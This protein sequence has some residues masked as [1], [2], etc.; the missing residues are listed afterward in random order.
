MVHAQLVPL[1]E[2]DRDFEMGILS[3]QL[4]SA[5]QTDTLFKD[6]PNNFK[7]ITVHQQLA[8]S[9]PP[10]TTLLAFTD[11][12][13]HSFK[14]DNRLFWAFQFHPEVDKQVLID[15]LTLYKKKYTNDDGHLAAILANAQETPESNKL[16]SK[17]VDRVL[18]Q[19]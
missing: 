2:K 12:C 17:F 14:V 13:C 18:L 16:V 3:M 9:E 8:L 5:A 1:S 10:D 6:T 19:I 11:Q 4:S 7:A 15:R